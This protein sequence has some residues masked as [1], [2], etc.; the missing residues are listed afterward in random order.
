MVCRQHEELIRLD[1]AVREGS[2]PEA[3]HDMRVAVRRLRSILRTSRP[4]LDQP[5]VD[6]LRRELGWLGELLGAVR[7]L[8]VLIETLQAEIDD[9]NGGDAGRAAGLLAP[10]HEERDEAHTRLLEGMAGSRYAALREAVRAVGETLPVGDA[11][12]SAQQLAADE[13]RRLR[14]RSRKPATLLNDA[15][16]HK[17]RIRVKRARYAA[18]LAEP[19]VG[20]K[21]SRFVHA[22]KDVQDVLGEHQDAVV[23]T[24]RLRQLA[25][26]S[27]SRG[28]ALVAGRL[29]EQQERRKLAVATQLPPAWRRLQ[30]AGKRA[31]RTS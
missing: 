21:A 9:L 19:V 30:K 26:K 6:E 3:V 29:L 12:A 20:K 13:F 10:L 27:P 28:A 17:R 18:E 5:W 7:D 15:Q 11:D 16:L 31:W 2:D 24:R 22:A 4:M 1:L 25:R 14:K 8:D 23:A